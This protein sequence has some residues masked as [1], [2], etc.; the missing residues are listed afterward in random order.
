MSKSEQLEIKESDQAGNVVATYIA[1]GDSRVDVVVRAF[2]TCALTRGGSAN[3]AQLPQQTRSYAQQLLDVF[4]P[5]G[6]P[7][8]VTEDYTRYA[9]SRASTSIK[10]R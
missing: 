1:S 6:Y 2:L 4:L 10:Q 8:S 9:T 3:D 5:A 7:H